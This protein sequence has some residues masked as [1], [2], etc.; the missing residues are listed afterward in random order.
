MLVMIINNNNYIDPLGVK[1]FPFFLIYFSM[2]INTIVYGIH[3]R[4]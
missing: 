2:N 1:T 4:C 3:P